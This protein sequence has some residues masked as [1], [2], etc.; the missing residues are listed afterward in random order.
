MTESHDNRE[1]GSIGVF[2]MNWQIDC[3]FL[4]NEIEREETII[5]V[6]LNDE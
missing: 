2:T 3:D 1:S 6:V 4:L 5:V